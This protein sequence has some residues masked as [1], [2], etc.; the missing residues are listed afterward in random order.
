M[1][2]MIEKIIENGYGY[3]VN[4]D[5]YFSVEKF[6][7]YGK[8]SGQNIDELISGTRIEPS[9]KKRSPLDFALWKMA[10]QDEPFWE[11][12]WGKGRPGWH[13]E[14]SA[15][16]SKY[17]GLPFDIHG[18][19]ID[20]RF[21]HH[22]NEIAQAE[23]ASG[24][25][26]AN[27]WIH[28]GL[29]TIRGDKM[30]KS[31]GNIVNICDLLKK[32]DPEV[33]RFFFG[34][35]HYRHP[36]DFNETA[37][38]NAEKGLT[39][40]HRVKDRLVL[41]S[42]LTSCTIDNRNKTGGN[43]E[44]LH[45]IIN[46]FKQSFE[47]AMDDDFNTPEAIAVMFEFINKTNKYLELNSNPSISMTKK[48]HDT[49]ISLGKILTLFQDEKDSDDDTK[50]IQSLNDIA[51]KYDSNVEFIDS[52]NEIMD[53]LLLLRQKAREDKKWDIADQIRNEIS[54]MGFEIQD[55]AKGPIWRRI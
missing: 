29:L 43:D 3:V 44:E 52:L 5:V 6:P 16:S 15:M 32:W 23:A 17:L 50:L 47:Y 4:G 55:S 27:Y 33:V 53:R 8:L 41:L 2:E 51:K 7:S 24:K 19:G 34:Q 12:P 36:P 21:P 45:N 11:S 35:T 54:C 49:L 13:I 20:L 46:E 48:A 25:S 14:C 9:D 1:I 37:L 30:S 38:K 18:G 28:S 10:K 39:R 22:E 31:L 42:D 26:F 40:I